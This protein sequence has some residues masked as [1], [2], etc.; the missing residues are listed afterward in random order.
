MDAVAVVQGLVDER[1]SG[2]EAGAKLLRLG[3]RAGKVLESRVRACGGGCRAGKLMLM[4]IRI[5]G[6]GHDMLLYWEGTSDRNFRRISRRR[7][8]FLDTRNATLSPTPWLEGIYLE[9]QIHT[10]Q[11]R[12][13]Q[14]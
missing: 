7:I 4:E 14:L 6:S 11:I 12:T 9:P 2:G 5:G 10:P 13:V 1:R 3:S 8:S